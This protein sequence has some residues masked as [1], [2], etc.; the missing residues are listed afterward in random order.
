MFGLGV[1]CTEDFVRHY[2]DLLVAYKDGMAGDGGVEKLIGF[3][4]SVEVAVIVGFLGGVSGR[5]AALKTIAGISSLPGRS[6]LL[7]FAP[8]ERTH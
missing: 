1:Q 3:D 5:K 8:D 4:G 6:L 7:L 2:A